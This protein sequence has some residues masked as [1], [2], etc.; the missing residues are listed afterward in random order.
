MFLVTKPINVLI[1]GMD[2]TSLNYWG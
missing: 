1:L 2:D